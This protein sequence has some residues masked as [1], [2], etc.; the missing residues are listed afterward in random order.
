MKKIGFIGA[1]EKTDL[2]TYTGRIL[3]EVGNKVLIIDTTLQQK[4]RYIVPAIAPTK[5]YVTEYED[6]DVAV[7]FDSEEAL[8]RYMGDIENEFD[9]IL[10]DVDEYEKFDSFDLQNAEKL[11]FVTAF[12]NY[13]LKRGIE[14]I[15][16]MREKVKMK[17]I[18]FEREITEENDEYLNLLTLTYP[19]EWEEE[20]IHFP[21]DQG[22]LTII[23]ENQRVSKIKIKNLSEEYRMGLY[24][25]VQEIAPE[26]KA[27]DLRKAFKNI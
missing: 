18:L 16:K 19:I 7:G 12:D 15:G 22:D 8:K 26:I 21:Y 11:Y 2:I 25:L 27:G 6:M 14:T 24:M 23:M 4:A 13:S 10:I 17:K 1:F 20:K 9:Y 5:S 3:T